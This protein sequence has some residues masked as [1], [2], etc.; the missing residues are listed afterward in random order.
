MGTGPNSKPV[1]RYRYFSTSCTGISVWVGMQ[2][3][4]QMS[5]NSGTIFR[6]KNS[7]KAKKHSQRE[8]ETVKKITHNRLGHVGLDP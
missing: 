4:T 8:C 2:S 1:Y 7:E 6:G 5:L 3:G